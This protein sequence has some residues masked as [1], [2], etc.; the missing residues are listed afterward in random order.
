MS[1]GAWLRSV[2]ALPAVRRRHELAS[3]SLSCD[4]P[5]RTSLLAELRKH[6]VLGGD[7]FYD[8]ERWEGLKVAE[9]SASVALA[10]A[11]ELAGAAPVRRGRG[12][13]RH[14][15]IG[16]VRVTL[17]DGEQIDAEAV[18][19]AIP[20][21]PLRDVAITGLSD[22]RLRVVA[23]AAQRARGEGRG[24]LRGLVLAAERAERPRRERVAVRL[25]L[26]AGTGSA[27][28]A[29]P[30][31][32]LRGLP[33]G[34]AGGS[35]GD[36]ARGLE[37]AVRRAGRSAGRDAR[38]AVGLGPVHARVHRELGARRPRRAS[39]R[40]TARTSRRST[41]PAPITGSPATWRGRCGQGA[42]RRERRWAQG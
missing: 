29:R 32:A 15:P 28:A 33:R 19:C 12:A 27:V 13:D 24:R 36:R 42:T 35:R 22:A 41:S 31:R 40:C 17:V 21:A 38:A 20:A 18:V 34:A 37:R 11:A 16:G 26:A 2:D 14:Q 30:A 25:D 5:E 7:G 8:L 4:A 3:L 39:G 10:M 1:V 6:A 9:G 23:L